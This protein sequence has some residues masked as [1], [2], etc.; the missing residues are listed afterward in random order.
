MAT[1]ERI[2]RIMP[3]SLKRAAR[4]I[5][6]QQKFNN[7]WRLPYGAKRIFTW[8]VMVGV[9]SV[10]DSASTAAFPGRSVD[11]NS[12]RLVLLTSQRKYRADQPI[13]ITAY[14]ENV[15]RDKTYYVGADLG[16]LFSIQSFHYIELEVVKADGRAVPIG[17]GAGTSLWKSGTTLA[18]KLSQ[19]YVQLRPGMI[20]GLRN[21]RD[22]RLQP[23]QYRLKAVYH[24]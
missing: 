18:E 24:E 3:R 17:R 7:R 15:S 14:L 9:L 22:L 13:P 16:D 20:L 23:G 8:I 12:I 4:M 2:R 10:L 5:H 21:D 6:M 11:S 19:E 1:W